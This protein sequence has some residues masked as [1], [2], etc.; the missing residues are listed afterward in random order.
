MSETHEAVSDVFIVETY[1]LLLMMLSTQSLD[2]FYC[3]SVDPQY[4]SVR[5][6]TA[7][8]S[9]DGMLVYLYCVSR[10]EI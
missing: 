2:R 1:L 4:P 9:N 6:L 10:R 5:N 8:M 7:S 3:R